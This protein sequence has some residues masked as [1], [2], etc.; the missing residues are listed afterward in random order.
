MRAAQKRFSSLLFAPLV[1]AVFLLF[2]CGSNE[3]KPTNSD[4]DVEA[5]AEVELNPLADCADAKGCYEM[6][7]RL[8]GK[9]TTANNDDDV[10]LIPFPYN[11]FAKTDD[12]TIT[13]LRLNLAYALNEF[14]I[15]TNSRIID[16]GLSFM[17]NKNYV[18]TLNTLDGFSAVGYIMF[19]T[20]EKIA[21]SSFPT[22]KADTANKQISPVLI[23]NV[24]KSSA[25]LAKPRRMRRC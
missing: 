5:E 16:T 25:D 8:N 14:F 2:S 11:Y 23:V 20:G 12:F 18:D 17:N 13:G 4:Q 10:N 24:D 15:T 7:Y 6:T 1:F 3:N 9:M 22:N 21:E 19:E